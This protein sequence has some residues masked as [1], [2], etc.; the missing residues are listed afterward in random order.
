MQNS[1]TFER[2]NSSELRGFLTGLILGDGFIDKGTNNRAF[3]IKT[4]DHHYMTHLEHI[5]MLSPFKFRVRY[6]QGYTDSKGVNH[7]DHW[8]LRTKAHPYFAKKY[9]WFYNDCRHRKI[10]TKTLEWLTP[11]GLAHW[12]M[13]DGYICLVGKESGII[14]DRRMEICTDRYFEEDVDLMI[15]VLWYK[16]KLKCSKI[17]RGK[18]FRIRI[19]KESYENFINL[20]SP[21]MVSTM[22]YKLWLGYKNKPDYLS[23]KA[24]DYQK[25]L[26]SAIPQTGKAVGED[27][28]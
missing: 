27:I 2:Y 1:K 4:I 25:Y 15:R 26:L 20:I 28:V 13:S 14:R 17:K 12:F 10:Y 22:K 9:H 5:F 24:W 16:F 6:V 3:E 11:M 8:V 23:D 18:C 19:R 21:F 7:K